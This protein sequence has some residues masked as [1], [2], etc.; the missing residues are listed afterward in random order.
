MK[1]HQPRLQMS[2]KTAIQNNPRTTLR[3]MNLLSIGGSDPSSG[4]GIQADIK[5]FEA[6]GA[7]GLCAITAITAQNT[8][9]FAG[10]EPVSQNML[11]M[12]LDSILSDFEISGIKIGMVY[13]SQAAKTI[14]DRL[15]IVAGTIPV[16]VDPVIQATT[17]GLLLEDSA[18]ADYVRFIAPLSTVMTPNLQEARRIQSVCA[19]AGDAR[20]SDDK[21]RRGEN[22]LGKRHTREDE[23]KDHMQTATRIL[24]QTGAKS[25]IITGLTGRDGK[26]GAIT[27]IL[28]MRGNRDGI[29]THRLP[30]RPRISETTHGGGCAFSAVVLYHIAAGM[31]IVGAAE[32]AQKY[33][34]ERMQDPPSPGAGMRIISAPLGSVDHMYTDLSYAISQFASISEIYR[35]IPECQTNFVYAKQSARSASDVLGIRGRIVRTG[36]TVSIAGELRYGGSKHAAAAVIAASEKF[37][38]IRSAINIRFDKRTIDALHGAGMTVCT[39]DRKDEPAETK[40]RGSTVRWGVLSAVES[41]KSAPDVIYHRGDYGKEPMIIVLGLTPADVIS[42]IKKMR[43]YYKKEHD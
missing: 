23:H 33:V 7:Y 35:Y 42:K 12:Q 10:A 18:L 28:A 41:A 5:T 9:R 14:S 32:M 6:H 37:P 43:T 24:R 40:S 13:T 22:A 3:T 2:Q 16:V 8:T 21:S 34:A 17:G 26:N 20:E 4:A 27:D 19:S 30:G 38:R 11:E 36:R 31:D 25:V 39:Y 15:A 29:R 1:T